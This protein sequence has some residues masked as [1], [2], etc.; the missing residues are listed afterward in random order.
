M[1]NENDVINRE[2]KMGE[3]DNDVKHIYVQASKNGEIGDIYFVFNDGYVER[4]EMV[5]PNLS[6]DVKKHKL[7]GLFKEMG[8]SKNKGQ[9]YTM[10]LTSDKIFKELDRKVEEQRREE[11]GEY[12]FEVKSSKLP[13]VLNLRFNK[14]LFKK[15]KKEEAKEEVIGEVPEFEFDEDDD[16][17]LSPKHAAI[18]GGIV[19]LTI[20]I[21]ACGIIKMTDANDSVID[22]IG[23]EASDGKEDTNSNTTTVVKPSMEG[24]DWNYYVENAPKNF[25]SE[26]LIDLYN[27]LDKFAGSESWMN[28]KI[29]EEDKAALNELNIKFEGEEAK[30]TFT[31]EEAFAF[32]L[33]YGNQSK[34]NLTTLMNGKNIEIDKVWE[35]SESL[36]NA[37]VR[38]MFLYYL[39]SD[40]CHTGIEEIKLLNWSEEDKNDFVKYE[41]MLR[42]W[43][44]L[45]KEEKYSEAKKEI[46]KI[47]EDFCE[48]A[49]QQDTNENYSKPVVLRLFEVLAQIS[50][51]EMGFQSNVTTTFYDSKTNEY[52]DKTVYTYTIDEK[53]LD[54]IIYGY[55]PCLNAQGIVVREGFNSIE[56]TKLYSL[57]S[58]RYTPV[59]PDDGVSIVDTFNG[60]ITSRMENANKFMNEL[61]EKNL[62]SDAAYLGGGGDANNT[63]Y[64]NS[65]S[66]FDELTK[67]SYDIE[68]V[69]SL[70]NDS[71]FKEGKYSLNTDVFSYFYSL[72]VMEIK[73]KLEAKT[74]TVGKGSSVAKKETL[75]KIV[76]TIPGQSYTVRTVNTSTVT[77]TEETHSY[78]TE[79]Q[80]VSEADKQAEAERKAE[81]AKKVEVIDKKT[82][83]KKIVSDQELH[84]S[85]E[86]GNDNLEPVD[87]ENKNT[88]EL[89]RT[90]KE[91]KEKKEQQEADRKKS[92]EEAKRTYTDEQGNTHYETGGDPV[93][94]N[95]YKS[96]EDSNGNIIVTNPETGNELETA[97]D[98]EAEKYNQQ[99]Q[100]SQNSNASSNTPAPS[101]NGNSNGNNEYT[102]E[103]PTT[104]PSFAPAY[105]EEV[106]AIIESMA[107]E[108]N[109]VSEASEGMSR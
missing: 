93:S 97:T 69:L 77:W 33:V 80:K 58:N 87:K 59:I 18:A 8:V 61:E 90:G 29:T 5:D 44:S 37:F 101:D 14:D 6:N 17:K 81:D 36:S 52:V 31:P 79:T 25:Q 21:G 108:V 47:K 38:K 30:L 16:A 84:D 86:N 107:N 24:Q 85:F 2:L 12:D 109:E 106:D 63:A 20:A 23:V 73:D 11:S 28:R 9:D 15:N 72:K 70:M 45:I 102:T 56:W 26:G 96:E 43:K 99:L 74:T 19:A 89:I 22:A 54:D 98:E 83:E 53:T 94:G 104:S 92:E 67:Y 39:L 3:A 40:E 48:Y 100:Q 27:F 62:T 4:L 64:L 57:D 42:N 66:E 55:N 1:I 65:N 71:L 88:Q 7:M 103:D 34:E 13:K 35:S 68:L 32:V 60:G 82:G 78:R 49:Y 46:E 41:D 95:G 75:S 76:K 91:D 50:N 105:E 10:A 51:N